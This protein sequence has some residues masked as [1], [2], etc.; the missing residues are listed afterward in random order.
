[1]RIVLATEAREG[2][3]TQDKAERLNA[4]TGH[5]IEE[6]VATFHPPG[7]AGGWQAKSSNVQWAL[8][9]LWMEN[10]VEHFQFDLS[11]V[12]MAVGV[13]TRDTSYSSVKMFVFKVALLDLCTVVRVSAPALHLQRTTREYFHPNVSNSTHVP[14]SSS[15]VFQSRSTWT[16]LSLFLQLWVG[17]SVFA[18]DRAE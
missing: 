12:F 18:V 17:S 5:L 3:N 14:V 15:S 1:M 2:L 7:V 10:G 4:E 13:L 8:R 11:S 9:Q 6:M 16:L